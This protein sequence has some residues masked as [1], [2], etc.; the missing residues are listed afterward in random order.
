VQLLNE[1]LNAQNGNVVKDLAKNFNLGE[2]ETQSALGSLLPALT[3]GLKRNTQAQGGLDS[4]LGALERGS[5]DRYL[6]QPG[7]ITESDAR[8]EG[9]KILGHILGNKQVSRN[10]A[11]NASQNTGLNEGLLKQMLPMVASLAMGALSKQQRQEPSSASSKS[12]LGSLLDQDGDGS[13]GDDL[14]NFAKKL[15]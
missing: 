3:A 12:I 7:R 6:E 2:K 9:N 4:L 13:V 11:R 10:V 5:H 8:Q 14:L 1:I 15:F